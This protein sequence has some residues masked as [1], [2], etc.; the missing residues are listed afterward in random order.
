MVYLNPPFPMIRGVSLLPDHERQDLLY[1]LPMSPHF[2]RVK[3]PRSG[4]NVPQFQ[5]V[6][7]RGDKG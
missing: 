5:L 4:Q 7:Y 1:Y 2:T 6:R 3:D